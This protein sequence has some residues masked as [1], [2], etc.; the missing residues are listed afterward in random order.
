MT[1]ILLKKDRERPS[2]LRHPWIYSGAIA[3]VD[4]EAEPGETV[5]VVDST[6]AFVAYGQLSPESQIRVRLLE[7]RE[8]VVVDETWW[9]DKIETAVSL[10]TAHQRHINSNAYRLIHAEADQLPGLV[11]D[12]YD[13]YIVLQALT[14][15]VEREKALIARCL[16]EALHPKGIYERSDVEVR[17]QEGLA[18]SRGILSGPEPPG[19]L[20]VSEGSAAFLVDIM[21]GQ[22]TG[23]Y[24]DQRDNRSIVAG[25]AAGRSVLDC[26]AYSGAFSVHALR[27]GAASATLIDSSRSALE[28]AGRNLA[29]N[30]LDAASAVCVEGSVPVV[31][32]SYRDARRTFDLIILDPPKFARSKNQV[33]KAMRA[34]KDINL[35]AMKLLN[36]GGLLATFS[37][38]GN[39]GLETF[40]E[41]VR[42]AALD[43]ERHV[44]I[45]QRLG[46]SIDHP[47]A[48]VFPASEYLKGLLCRVV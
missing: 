22:K 46:Q 40:S 14:A 35:L 13:G 8:A 26:Y 6:G 1:T 17:S 37:C 18:E 36:P 28:I 16:D 38:S 15:G 42:W 2:R 10:R 4:G 45:V 48:S 47:V 32:R 23:F 25:Y 19:I 30:G 5:R 27:S 31:L 29:L 3:R 41:I 7:W 34:Y 9:R 21:R 20:E 43:A 39:I 44:Q 33:D 24:L 12:Y 11:V